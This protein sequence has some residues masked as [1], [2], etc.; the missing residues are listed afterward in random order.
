MLGLTF[1]VHQNHLESSLK[2]PACW[3]PALVSV[4]IGGWGGDLRTCT[5]SSFPG[6]PDA[7]GDRPLGLAAHHHGA[8][9]ETPCSLLHLFHLGNRK[10]IRG[11]MDSLEVSETQ[12]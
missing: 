4:G 12:M 6:A 9:E 2:P 7:S 5:A 1:S 11:Q 8:K 3:A 10:G